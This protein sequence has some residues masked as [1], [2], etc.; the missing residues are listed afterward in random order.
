MLY[1]LSQQIIILSHIDSTSF[2]RDSITWSHVHG[3]LIRESSTVKDRSMCV[4]CHNLTWKITIFYTGWQRKMFI[5][6][7]EEYTRFISVWLSLFILLNC[8]ISS[9]LLAQYRKGMW[10]NRKVMLLKDCYAMA[11]LPYCD[12]LHYRL[13]SP[14]KAQSW[15][16]RFCQSCV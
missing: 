7:F 8:E 13:M 5:V 12:W 9:L 3:K 15:T 2:S 14:T 4:T 6:N 11:N 16:I 1:K 10:M